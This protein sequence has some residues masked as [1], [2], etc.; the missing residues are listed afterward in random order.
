MSKIYT[1]AVVIIPPQEKWASI[2]EIRKIY[3]RNLHR[4]MPHITLL[5]PFRPKNE[6][7][8]LEKDFS[9][10][11][12]SISPFE[13]ILRDFHYFNHGPQRYTLWLR[14]EPVDLIKDLQARILKIVPDCND[15]NKY[16]KGFNPHLSVG[17]INGKIK[18]LKIIENLQ[19]NW[20]EIR[21]FLNDIFFIAREKSKTSK[22]EIK[23]RIQLKKE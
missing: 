19:N 2:Q 4:W 7:P 11:G 9:E 8:I 15:V 12:K 20:H 1:S 18:L 14:P 21:F 3:D 17:Q 5:Y 10:I 6:Y 23:K 22:F 16:K 13:I